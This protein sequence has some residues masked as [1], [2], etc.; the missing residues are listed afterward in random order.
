MES[1]GGAT[2]NK[3]N[4][5]LLLVLARPPLGRAAPLMSDTDWRRR[6]VVTSDGGGGG[7]EVIVQELPFSSLSLTRCRYHCH[8]GP[9]PVRAHVQ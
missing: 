1:H 2:I 8:T 9:T 3:P 7:G 5:L 6:E 4:F